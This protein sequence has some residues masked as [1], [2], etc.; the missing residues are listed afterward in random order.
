M[1][2]TEVCKDEHPNTNVYLVQISIIKVDMSLEL[3]KKEGFY[4]N[5]TCSQAPT[6]CLNL[7]ESPKGEKK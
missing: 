5:Q 1:K 4:L 3:D 7:E 6:N 2:L